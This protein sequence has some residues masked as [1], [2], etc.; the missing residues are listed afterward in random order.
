MVCLEHGKAILVP[1]SY[2]LDG[3]AMLLCIITTYF[4]EKKFLVEEYNIF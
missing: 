3:I 4:N 1:S 2:L